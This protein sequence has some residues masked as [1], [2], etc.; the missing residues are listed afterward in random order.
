[1]ENEQEVSAEM[2]DWIRKKAHEYAPI[3]RKTRTYYGRGAVDAYLKTREDYRSTLESTCA[4]NRM[5]SDRLAAAKEE[6]KIYRKALEGIREESYGG[7]I[8]RYV[9]EALEKYPQR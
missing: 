5:L 9:D 1:M 2:A 4:A 8:S 7:M 3:H 6:A